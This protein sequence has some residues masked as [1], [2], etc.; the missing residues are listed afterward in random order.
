MSARRTVRIALL[1][2]D[3]IGPEVV[4]EAVRVLRRVEQH[5]GQF[6]LEMTTFPWGVDHRDRTGVIAPADFV[7]QLQKFDVILLGALGDPRRYPDHITLAPLVQ[8]RQRFDQYVCTRPA[9]LFP[10]VRSVLANAPADSIDIMILREN[11]EGE[12][13][14]FGGRFAKGSVR[15]VAVQTAV[16][17]RVGV[18][19]ILRFGYRLARQRRKRLTMITKSNALVWGMTLWDDVL[20]EI[21]TEYPDVES[22]RQ[23]ADAAAMD[24][25]RR[26][27]RYDVVVASNLF[28][29]LLSDLA[30]GITGGMGLAPSANINVERKYPSMFEP[31]HGSAPDIVGRGIANPIATILSAAMMLEWLEFADA[32]KSIRNAVV[33]ALKDGA[34]TA[35]IGG[36]MTTSQVTD[37]I[38]ERIA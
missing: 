30:A 3:G 32:A 5:S 10:G 26:P 35:D 28:G 22:E 9:R 4:T 34:A 33:S 31:V 7:D 38:I 11:S 17:T 19:R 29:D 21:R 15:E 18:E 37:Q 36:S 1:P 27:Q 14:P 24:F 20:D 12:Y 16:H 23:H 2:G 8:L 6:V 25:V 13:L